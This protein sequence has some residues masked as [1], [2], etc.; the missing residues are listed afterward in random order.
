[1]TEIS[2]QE[3]MVPLDEYATVA[4]DATL[5]EA[6]GAVEESLQKCAERVYKHRALVALNREGRVVGKLSQLDVLR[7]LEPKR[8]RFNGHQSGLSRHG[9]TMDYVKHMVE[10]NQPH[11]RPLQGLCDKAAELRVR[12]IMSTPQEGEYV[13]TDTSLDE[14]VHRL[15]EGGHHSLLVT[16]GDRVVGVLRSSDVFVLVGRAVRGCKQRQQAA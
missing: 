11:R 7:G 16:E 15:V 12:D 3:I 13:T 6:F 1:M 8:R 5:A 4:E 10:S 9:L 14:A 2:V